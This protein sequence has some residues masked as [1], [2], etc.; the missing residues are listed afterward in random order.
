[1]CIRDP[2]THGVFSTYCSQWFGVK[3]LQHTQKFMKALEK[4]SKLV[5]EVV[6]FLFSYKVTFIKVYGMVFIKNQ[7]MICIISIIGKTLDNK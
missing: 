7:C 1:M 6:S 2:I 5:Q 4:L 3:A